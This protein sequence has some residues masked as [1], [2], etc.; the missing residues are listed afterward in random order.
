MGN[1]ASGNNPSRESSIDFANLKRQILATIMKE[2]MVSPTGLDAYYKNPDYDKGG[3]YGK[4]DF[5]KSDPPHEEMFTSEQRI[6]E[7]AGAIESLTQRVASLESRL[8]GGHG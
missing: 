2:M 8:S 5:G 3:L 1:Q 7:L 6:S 4:G